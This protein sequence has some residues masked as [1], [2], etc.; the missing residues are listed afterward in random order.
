MFRNGLAGNPLAFG[1]RGNGPARPDLG[2]GTFVSAA[3]EAGLTDT[4]QGR[5]AAC[6]DADRDGDLDIVITNNQSDSSVVFY[7]NELATGDNYLAI[8]LES[9]GLNT[10]G[11]GAWISVDDDVLVRVREIHGGNNF[12]SQSPAEAHFGLGSADSVDVTVNWPD[13]SQTVM[14]GV[15][16]NQK[17]TIVQQ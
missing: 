13:G 11:I 6:F 2:D 5:G 7:R 10:A 17:L 14:T 3:N 9:S 4:G 1:A 15:S 8:N 12:V 16:A